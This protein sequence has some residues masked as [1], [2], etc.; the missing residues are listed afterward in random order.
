MNKK[1]VM[2]MI[3]ART[4]DEF[5]QLLKD[6][7]A[8]VKRYS[9]GF[10][11]LDK[12][13]HGGL[14]EDFAIIAGTYSV[15]K[16]ALII[17]MMA[18]MAKQGNIIYYFNFNDIEDDIRFR[19]VTMEA[20]QQALN[21]FDQDKA[22]QVTK[23]FGKYMSLELDS[24]DNDEIEVYFSGLNAFKKYIQ[25]IYWCDS[26]CDVH[27][28]KQIIKDAHKKYG[29]NIVVFIDAIQDLN[30]GEFD[31]YTKQLNEISRTIAMHGLCPIIGIFNQEIGDN[32]SKRYNKGDY[33][34]LPEDSIMLDYDAKLIMNISEK[35][36]L[37]GTTAISE[38]EILK[39]N[40]GKTGD[41]IHFKYHKPYNYFSECNEFDT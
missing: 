5:I 19:F 37:N 26:V 13:L 3:E 25:N 6:G 41:K 20:Y 15:G 17:Q 36:R 40:I 29:N 31:S 35:K 2:K 1:E 16:T 24:M 8:T 10:H 28:I 18:H 9:T 39:Y 11:T 21:M 4:S 30:V 32:I 14:P 33:S 22:A 27:E 7:T 34:L 38:I 23:S 12:V